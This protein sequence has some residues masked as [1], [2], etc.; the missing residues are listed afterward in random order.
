MALK[1]VG[2]PTSAAPYDHGNWQ[3]GSVNH[4]QYGAEQEIRYLD[5]ECLGSG[6]S[7]FIHW[8]KREQIGRKGSTAGEDVYFK[9]MFNRH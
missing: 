1:Q 2:R 5:S 3:R 7:A 8:M 9:S 6:V 4:K